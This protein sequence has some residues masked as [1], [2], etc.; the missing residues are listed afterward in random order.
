MEC[1]FSEHFL[2]PCATPAYSSF[3]ESLPPVFV[4]PIHQMAP[5][6]ELISHEMSR[7][8]AEE[9]VTMPPWRA[10]RAIMSKWAP[11][12]ATDRLPSEAASPRGASFTSSTELEKHT[13]LAHKRESGVEKGEAPSAAPDERRSSTGSFQPCEKS[14]GPCERSYMGNS[15]NVGSLGTVPAADG[16]RTAGVRAAQA[17]HLRRSSGGSSPALSIKVGFDFPGHRPGK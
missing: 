16:T 3:Y 4:G 13:L 1:G 10:S 17:R 8:F 6:V 15:T 11:Q 2:I 5:L 9:G 12:K 7:S 14:A